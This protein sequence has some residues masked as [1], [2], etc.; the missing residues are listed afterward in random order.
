MMSARSRR[1]APSVRF[2]AWRTA[3]GGESRYSVEAIGDRE[4]EIAARRLELVAR[5]GPGRGE[6]Q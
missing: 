5:K 6:R 1:V 3:I 4:R 2:S